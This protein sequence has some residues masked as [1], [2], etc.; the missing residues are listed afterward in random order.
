MTVTEDGVEFKVDL[1]TCSYSSRTAE[2]RDYIV[3]KLLSREDYLCEFNSGIGLL[4]LRAAKK[5][6]RVICSSSDS[7]E[8]RVL[9][10]TAL[11][12]KCLD[13]VQAF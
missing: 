11:S 5:G 10:L 13:K 4:P 12:Q 1:L 3:Q 9:Q 2:V 8:Y 7:N 6:S